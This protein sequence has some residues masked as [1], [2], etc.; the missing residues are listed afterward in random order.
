[1]KETTKTTQTTQTTHNTYA[2]MNQAGKMG[3]GMVVA[4]AGLVGAWGLACMIGALSSQ[5]IGG[6]ING[7]MTAITGM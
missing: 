5:G 4:F 7:F 1:M 2:D 6:V 3:L